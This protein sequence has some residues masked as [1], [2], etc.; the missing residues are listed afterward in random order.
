MYHKR[1][2]KTSNSIHASESIKINMSFL[3]DLETNDNVDVGYRYVVNG[4]TGGYFECIT[5][6]VSFSPEKIVLLTKRKKLI[7]SGEKLRI[8]KYYGKDVCV[9][10]KIDKVETENV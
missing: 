4:E 2:I 7:L 3:Q 6:I 1:E 5:D 8:Q 10:G 9:K